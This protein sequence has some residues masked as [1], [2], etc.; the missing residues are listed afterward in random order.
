MDDNIDLHTDQT[1]GTD[2]EYST[3]AYK[4]YEAGSVPYDA[5]IEADLSS[6]LYIYDEYLGE[7]KFT[8]IDKLKNLLEIKP[9]IILAGPPGTSKTYMAFQLIALL[10][11]ENYRMDDSPIE[12][13]SRTPY[14]QFD[15]AS[16]VVQDGIKVVWDIVQFNPSYGY[17]DF[18]SGIVAKSEEGTLIFKRENR[19]FIEL[20]EAARW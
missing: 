5:S 1:L 16:S 6:L 18:V 20:V 2:Y 4:L 3:I 10:G 13:V 12:L 14:M 15:S 7:I 17:E 8:K 11:D 9:Q 19:I